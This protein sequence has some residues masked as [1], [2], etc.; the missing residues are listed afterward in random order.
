M[1][2][3]VTIAELSKKQQQSFHFG[4]IKNRMTRLV[5]GG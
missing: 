5:G 2:M 4:F 3:T 1:L